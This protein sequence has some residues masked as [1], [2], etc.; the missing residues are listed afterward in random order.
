[1]RR[2]YVLPIAAVLLAGLAGFLRA[3]AEPSFEGKTLSQWM[4]LLKEV[5]KDP[6]RASSDWRKAPWAVG[7]IGVPALP[8][9]IEALDDTNAPVRLRAIRPIVVM[10]AVASDA[11]PVLA[12]HLADSDT[13]VR[14][15]SAVALGQIG[16]PAAGAVP[17][18]AEALKDSEPAVRQAAAAALGAIG[19]TEAIDPLKDAVGDP[20]PGV[21]RA[22]RVAL[23]HLQPEKP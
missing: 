6:A 14:Q 9:L 5:P 12:S 2:L 23:Q 8:S 20:S 13:Q 16:P 17:R 3:E 10:G 11:A 7:K 15:W 19:G 21:Q 4:A 18:L 22:A 1:M